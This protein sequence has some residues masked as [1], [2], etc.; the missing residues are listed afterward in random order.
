MTN[1]NCHE[2]CPKASKRRFL[3]KNGRFS[4]KKLC[5]FNNNAPKRLKYGLKWSQEDTLND[6]WCPQTVF[7]EIGVKGAKYDLPATSGYHFWLIRKKWEPLHPMKRHFFQN[8]D[9]GALNFFLSVK[10]GTL[11]V[12]WQVYKG[13]PNPD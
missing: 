9:V 7:F 5:K 10:N 4:T 6:P 1:K 8:W 13:L 3:S 12:I 11:E 2:G